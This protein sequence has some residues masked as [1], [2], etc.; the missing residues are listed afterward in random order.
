M[1]QQEKGGHESGSEKYV[2]VADVNRIKDCL[3]A[4]VRLRHIVNASAMLA[5][6]NETVTKKIVKDKCGEIIFTAGGVTQA[7]FSD[8]CCTINLSF[9]YFKA[10]FLELQ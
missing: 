2:L 9:A 3:F 5:Y 1:N 7:I 8:K 6:V 4:S 10:K